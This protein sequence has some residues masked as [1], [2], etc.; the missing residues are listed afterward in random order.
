[1][2]LFYFI[3]FSYNFQTVIMFSLEIMIRFFLLNKLYRKIQ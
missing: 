2:Q 1:M 3:P